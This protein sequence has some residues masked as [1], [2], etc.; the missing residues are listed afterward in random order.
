MPAVEVTFRTT[1][2]TD[3]LHLWKVDGGNRMA[4]LYEKVVFKNHNSWIIFVAEE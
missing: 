2:L 3:S 1:E 4:G